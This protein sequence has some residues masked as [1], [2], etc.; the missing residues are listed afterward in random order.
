MLGAVLAAH[1]ALGIWYGMAVPLWE[2]PDE[3][4]HY[5]YAWFLATE[6]RFPTEM[7]PL[8]C[9][10]TDE[11]HQPPFYY[12]ARRPADPAARPR[13]GPDPQNPYFSWGPGPTRNAW[14][15][16]GA[17]EWFPYREWVL[18]AHWM[19]VLSALFDTLASGRSTARAG[20]SSR[21]GPGSRSARPRSTPSAPA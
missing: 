5:Q 17:D 11:A 13:A 2:A 14:V 12:V 10:D 19:R 18:S 9:P 3:P 20:S 6:R 1:V 7:M 21:T 8:L 4:D 16:H 15:F